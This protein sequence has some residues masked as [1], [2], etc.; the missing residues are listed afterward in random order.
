MS[1]PPSAAAIVTPMHVAVVKHLTSVNRSEQKLRQDGGLKSCT[2]NKIKKST[3]GKWTKKY[4][5][6]VL[7]IK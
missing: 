7:I 4:F 5:F 3:I 2:K 6:S 1:G